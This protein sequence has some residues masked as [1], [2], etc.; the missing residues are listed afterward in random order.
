M[1]RIKKQQKTAK[2]ERN[3]A[4]Y[5]TYCRHPEYTLEDIGRQYGISRQRVLQIVRAKDKLEEK[6]KLREGDT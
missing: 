4:I 5:E 2:P 3:Q 1:L 6:M